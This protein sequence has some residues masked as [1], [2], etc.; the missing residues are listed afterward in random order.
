MPWSTSE[1]RVRLAFRETG[2]N[3]QVKYFTDR[4]RCF[5]CGSLMLF[6]S[7]F[8]YAFVH[9]CL[10]MPCGHLLGKGLPLGSLLW[11][12]IGILCQLW[13]LILSISDLC[14]LSYFNLS[15]H[16]FCCLLIFFSSQLFQKILSGMPLECQTI[17]IQIQPAWSGSKLF[18]TKIISRRHYK[19]KSY[20]VDDIHMGKTFRI[21]PEFRI[22]R[23]TFL[24]RMAIIID[25][26]FAICMV[27][28]AKWWRILHEYSCFIEF[29]TR[30]MEKR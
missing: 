28:A 20:Y 7:C 13:C 23:L 19:E 6:L 9:I 16:A 15:F 12:L 10:L 1:L 24:L 29:I 8:C 26:K 14:P 25:F 27:T 17:W 30:V 22:L 21:I 11:C 18:A 5:F 4:R 2:L 3:H